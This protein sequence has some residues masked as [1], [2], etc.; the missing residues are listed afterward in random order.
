MKDIESRAGDDQQRADA[1]ATRPSIAPLFTPFQI[2]SLALPNRIVMAPMTR[3]QSPGGVPGDDVVG[4]YRRRAEHGVGLII[5]EGT[6]IAHPAS[7]GSPRVPRFYGDDA[8]AG[9][10]KVS[11]AVHEAGGRIIPQLW[12]VG[13]ARK[14][15]SEPNPE[16]PPVGPSGLDLT[17][18]KISEPLTGSE[19]TDLID[20]YAQG[21][22]DALRLGFDGVELHGAHGYLIDQFFWRKTNQRADAYGGDLVGRTRFAVEVVKACRRRTSPQFPIVLRFSQWK[23]QDYD[24]KL[25]ATADE[26]ARFLA[27]LVDAGVDA[28]HCSTRRFWV[29]ELEG[30]ELNLAGWTKKL[31]GKPTITVG[32]VGLDHDF[33]S[34]LREGKPASNAGFEAVVGMIQRGEVDLVAVGRAL[35]VD[36]AWAEKIR[37]ERFHD[38]LPF[39]PEALKALS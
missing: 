24:A 3:N 12:H 39:A 38:L 23:L 7:S 5:T 8:L 30:S 33:V 34:S 18:A 37:E 36:P 14:P 10:A 19:V 13:M 11:R 17:G 22:A 16:A 28:F 21:A 31:T 29:P 20:A 9:W 25:V 6:V 35:L 2:K 15:G 1:F 26:L 27:P 32:S 4:Y